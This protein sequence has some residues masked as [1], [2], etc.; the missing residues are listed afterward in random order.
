MK[1]LVLHPPMYPI[2]YDFYNYLGKNINL[3][4]FQFGEYPNDHPTWSA[5]KLANK[6]KFFKLKIFGTGSDSFRN[7]LYAFKI[8]EIISIKPDIVLSIAFW[9][10]SFYYSILSKFCNFKFLI[11]TNA[12]PASESNNSFMRTLYRKIICINSDA[13]ISASNLTTKYLNSLSIS[14]K[15][16]LSIQTID[17]DI[18]QNQLLELDNKSQL[19]EELKLPKNKTILLSVGNF[20]LLKNWNSVFKQINYVNNCFYILIGSGELKEDYLQFITK[21]NLTDKVLIVSKKEQ[22]ELQKYYKA[23]DIFIFPSFKD[24]FGFVVLEALASSIPVICSSKVGA[25]CLITNDYNGY[26]INP[27]ENFDESISKCITNITVMKK[28]ALNSV[29]DKTLTNRAKEFYSI[30]KEVLK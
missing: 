23:S 30:F 17:T 28:N 7:Q 24:T 16:Y 22:H 19:R 10:P 21:N 4:I 15:Q 20:I 26:I 1:V 25:S 18:W 27:N 6:K 12:I 9:L 2:N 29:K 14:T 13:L 8:K 5:K 11:L 3:V